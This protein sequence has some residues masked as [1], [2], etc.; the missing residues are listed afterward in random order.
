MP[1]TFTTDFA[2][3]YGKAIGTTAK[4]IHAW[5]AD[6][7]RHGKLKRINRGV[8]M[9]TFLVKEIVDSNGSI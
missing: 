4:S 5:V 3:E 1:D 2:K 9:K 6:F 8:Y 7:V